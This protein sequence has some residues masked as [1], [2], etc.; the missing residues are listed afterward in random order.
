MK[1]IELG[2]IGE[3]RC[4]PPAAHAASAFGN[5]GVDVVSSPALIGYLEQAAH[6]LMDAYYENGEGSVGVGFEMRHLAAAALDREVVA[7][8]RLESVDG[9]RYRFAVEA[10]QDDRLVMEGHHERAVINLDRFMRRTR[11]DSGTSR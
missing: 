5:E 10:R 6:A 4:M 1:S 3:F 7:N 9:R 2:A 11:L 8:A